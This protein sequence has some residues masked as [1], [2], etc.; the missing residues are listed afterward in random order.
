MVNSS[1]ASSGD[2][3]LPHTYPSSTL[4]PK[5]TLVMFSHSL[6]IKLDDNNYLPWKHQV[7]HSIKG[8][9][10]LNH[11]DSTQTHSAASFHDFDVNVSHSLPSL[12]T[13]ASPAVTNTHPLHTRAKAGIRKPKVL[14]ATIEPSSVKDA[15]SSPH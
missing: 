5:T 8:S 15:L 13:V 1:T 12:T 3:S 4:L 11:L 6:S 14:M 2:S 9:R 10:L 7:F